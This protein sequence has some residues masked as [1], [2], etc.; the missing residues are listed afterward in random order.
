MIG[1]NGLLTGESLNALQHAG[2]ISVYN[3]L[4]Q[5]NWEFPVPEEGEVAV[6]KTH[7]TVP[8][9]FLDSEMVYETG[10]QVGMYAEGDAS[11]LTATETTQG[12]AAEVSGAPVLSIEQQ[13]VTLGTAGNLPATIDITD[14]SGEVVQRL[15][16]PQDLHLEPGQT[17]VLI[18]DDDGQPQLAVINSTAEWD[19][20]NQQQMAMQV[21]D[22]PSN[23]LLYG[24]VEG[25]IA[26]EKENQM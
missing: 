18:Q 4:Q 8:D 10:E 7:T 20:T 16:I 9:D 14:P 12:T 22:D 24:N 19:P 5:N 17:L 3:T 21:E 1:D 11:A 13:A 26:E 25:D 15:L 23:L 6:L 2:A